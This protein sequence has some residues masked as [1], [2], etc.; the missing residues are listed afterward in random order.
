MQEGPAYD[1]QEL[2]A[3]LTAIQR[4]ANGY[5]RGALE[6]VAGAWI[7]AA[8]ESHLELVYRELRPV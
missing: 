5:A 3:Q 6:H 2:G 1:M 4:V 8:S 7:P